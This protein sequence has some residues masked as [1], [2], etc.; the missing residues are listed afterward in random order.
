MHNSIWRGELWITTGKF[1]LDGLLYAIVTALTFA[2][3]W[4]ETA[5]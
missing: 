5:A 1:L 2:W 3:L 4:P